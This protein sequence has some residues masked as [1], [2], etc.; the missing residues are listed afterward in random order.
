MSLMW[1]EAPPLS[2]SLSLRE[3]CCVCV[4]VVVVGKKK[5]PS[6]DTHL[7][8]LSLISGNNGVKDSRLYESP[9]AWLSIVVFC[10]LPPPRS[11]R[12]RGRMPPH[13]GK[14]RQLPTDDDVNNK[15]DLM[16]GIQVYGILS[17]SLS[18]S[19]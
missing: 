2:L 19:L 3:L 5:T 13:M 18:L 12:E 6:S 8:V 15:R 10:P 11:K 14:K 1:H 17:V 9:N 7:V 16:F 4:V